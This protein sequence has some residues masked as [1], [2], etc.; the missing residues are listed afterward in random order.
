MKKEKEDKTDRKGQVIKT[1]CFNCEI[2][3]NQ[4]IL[5][6]EFS[7]TPQEI[8]W[9]NE[10][11]DESKSA[12]LVAGN[13]WMIS[14]C[15]GCDGINFKHILRTDRNGTDRVFHFPK[16]PIRQIPNWI[17]KLP[18]KYVEVLQEVYNSINDEAFILSLIGIRTVLDIFIVS[19]V[20]DS[21]TFK[22]KLDQLVANGIITTTKRQVLEAAIDAG[23]ASAHRGY[24][25]EKEVL[26]QI[27]DI[28]ENLLQS[29]IVDRSLNKIKEKTPP[30]N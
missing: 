23:N 17:I 2:E 27:L 29:E 18:M 26:F 5:F 22:N 25:P 20:G 15:Q 6:D 21:G 30:R 3:T 8:L 13:I 19:K 24:K 28:V 10:E 9:R 11:G 1:H 7:L 12:W 14:K 4:V 16:K